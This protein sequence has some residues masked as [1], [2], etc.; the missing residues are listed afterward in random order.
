M[1]DLV[2]VETTIP[3][4]YFDTRSK[5]EMQ[6]RRKWT[7]LW[8]GLPKPETVLVTGFAVLAELALAPPPKRE[9]A[10]DLIRDLEVLPPDPEIDEIVAVYL[11]NKLM[12]VEALG[13]AHHLALASYHHCDILVTWNCKHI[14][15]TN[16]LPHIRRVNALLGLETPALVTP[17]QLLEKDDENET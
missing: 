9:A 6:A 12:P 1:D 2:Y 14:A 4:F 7:R 11:A 10:L 3:S 17:L 16:K 13:D 8:W 15:N 5:V